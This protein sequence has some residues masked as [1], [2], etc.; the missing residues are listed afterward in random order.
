MHPLLL[1]FKCRVS[2]SQGW[3]SSWASSSPQEHRDA[4]IIGI[5]TRI[6]KDKMI[7]KMYENYRNHLG[8]SDNVVD[9][10]LLSP[11]PRI[12]NS[13]VS[14]SL[15]SWLLFTITTLAS[16][17]LLLSS[18]SRTTS[19]HVDLSSI[20]VFPDNLQKS[21]DSLFLAAGAREVKSPQG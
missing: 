3:A 15:Q 14:G 5:M 12:L 10:T 9:V 1:I 8:I 16:S 17:S 6:S 19:H 21:H 20:C 13:S 18:I 4:V 2:P 7:Q 11:L